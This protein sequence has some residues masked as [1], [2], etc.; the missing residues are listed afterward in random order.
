MESKDLIA[1]MNSRYSAKVFDSEKKVSED[2]LQALLECLRLSPSFFGIEAWK[3]VV[4]ENP[5]I[6][7]RLRTASYD[8]PKITDASHL[9][10]LCARKD[11]TGEYVD[12]KTRHTANVQNVPVES[13]R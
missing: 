10:V 4:V 2:T 6:R 13:L 8:Q 12:A 5:E 1:A 3:F 11:V 9:V 7:K